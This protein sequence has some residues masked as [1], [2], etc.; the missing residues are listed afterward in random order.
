MKYHNH[1]R[2]FLFQLKSHMEW[3]SGSSKSLVEY[4]SSAILDNPVILHLKGTLSHLTK[5]LVVLEQLVYNSIKFQ[6]LWSQKVNILHK[7][8]YL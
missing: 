7:K 2:R 6:Y 1:Y 4:H 3:F 5:W 8:I